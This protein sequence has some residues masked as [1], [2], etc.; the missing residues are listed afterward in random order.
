MNDDF[1]KNYIWQKQLN[2]YG[3]TPT[4]FLVNASLLVHCS[5]ACDKLL[6]CM[7]EVRGHRRTPSDSSHAEFKDMMLYDAKSLLH[8]DL[9][10][11]IKTARP[12]QMSVRLSSFDFPLYP[13]F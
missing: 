10:K 11:L 1:N 4:T 8:N 13:T 7:Q 2:W 9:E 3:I 5:T 6:L 12:E